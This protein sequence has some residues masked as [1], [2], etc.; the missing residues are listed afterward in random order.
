MD[1]AAGLDEE[2]YI[3]VMLEEGRSNYLCLFNHMY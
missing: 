1:G 3:D 2:G